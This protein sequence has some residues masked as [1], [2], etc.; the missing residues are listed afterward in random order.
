MLGI[1]STA[2]WLYDRAAKDFT[3]SALKPKHFLA[4]DVGS[5]I[6]NDRVCKNR[7]KKSSDQT[8]P[9]AKDVIRQ[10][11]LFQTIKFAKIAVKSLQIKHFLLQKMSLGRQFYSKRSSLQKSRKKSLQIKHFLLQ[12]MSL[13]RQFYSKQSSLQKS[14][15][16]VL[17]SN[18]SYCKRCRQVDSFIPN[19]RVC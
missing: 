6:Q 3:D 12:K 2:C 5:F 16:K 1:N 15:K 9:I 10:V 14:R 19:D 7:G 8:F 18:I 17:R 4:K 11:V 13:G